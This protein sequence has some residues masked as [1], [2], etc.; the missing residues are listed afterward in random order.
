M[1]KLKNNIEYIEYIKNKM[2]SI[3]NNIIVLDYYIEQTDG[4][5]G[6][7]FLYNTDKILISST[8]GYIGLDIYRKEKCIEINQFDEKL[9]NMI[10][11][12]DSINYHIEFL[13]EF[14]K[15]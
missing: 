5:F 2:L 12:V 13:K 14:Y 9:N 10:L 8:R 6:V 7:Y 3:F 4:R 11:S 1:V 15:N